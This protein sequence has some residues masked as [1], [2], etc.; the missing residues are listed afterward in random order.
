MLNEYSLIYF[1]KKPI[2][3][4]NPTCVK[5]ICPSFMK[6]FIVSF[7]TFFGSI[8]TRPQGIKILIF[9]HP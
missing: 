9:T 8:P 1:F 7:F 4:D 2:F 3:D 6:F 5:V